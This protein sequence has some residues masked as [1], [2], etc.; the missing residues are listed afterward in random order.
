[1]VRFRGPRHILSDWH[2][3]SRGQDVQNPA[4][5]K[6]PLPSLPCSKVMLILIE[7]YQ[8]LASTQTKAEITKYK[9]VA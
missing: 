1:M 7:K 9:G 4:D 5:G 6:R 3:L 2:N 8:E